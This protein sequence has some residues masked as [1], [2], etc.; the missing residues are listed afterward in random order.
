ML[1]IRLL[2]VE[3]V[4]AVLLTQPF[5]SNGEISLWHKFQIWGSLPYPAKRCEQAPANQD[6]SGCLLLELPHRSVDELLTWSSFLWLKETE[7]H[8]KS[9]KQKRI[10]WEESSQAVCIPVPDSGTETLLTQLGPD[11]QPWA[12]CCAWWWSH[13][14][15]TLSWDPLMAQFVLSRAERGKCWEDTL[16][17]VHCSSQKSSVLS[18]HPP[19]SQQA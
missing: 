15:L 9:L 13:T 18:T 12:L 4:F 10:Y 19:P 11:V 16:K 1:L 2:L 14:A 8:F 7:T 5:W 17:V 3:V 6:P